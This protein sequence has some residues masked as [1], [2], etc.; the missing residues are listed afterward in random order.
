MRSASSAARPLE[1]RHD[2][3]VQ[4]AVRPRFAAR[5]GAEQ[6]DALG[7]HDG[8]HAAERLGDER[9]LVG[10]DVGRREVEAFTHKDFR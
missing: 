7:L 5:V 10:P 2:E 1:R 8:E 6:D 4:V 3:Q 9:E